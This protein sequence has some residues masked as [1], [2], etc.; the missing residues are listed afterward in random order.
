[1]TEA[2][3]SEVTIKV[4]SIAY[5]NGAKKEETDLGETVVPVA[6]AAGPSGSSRGLSLVNEASAEK[7][8]LVRQSPVTPLPPLAISPSMRVRK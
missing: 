3:A 6:G 5:H 1:M 8:A 7:P 2:T 4:T